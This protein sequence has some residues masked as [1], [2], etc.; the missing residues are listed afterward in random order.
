M[1]NRL[2]EVK[3]SIL[4]ALGIFL[5]HFLSLNWGVFLS[6]TYYLDDWPA[7]ALR[8]AWKDN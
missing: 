5:Q 1:K 2:L 7:Q 8:G 6:G 4:S 3:E